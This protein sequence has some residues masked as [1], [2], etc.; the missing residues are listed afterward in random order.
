MEKCKEFVRDFI[1]IDDAIKAILTIANNDNKYRIFN[2][3]SGCGT[4]IKQLIKEIEKTLSLEINVIY[5]EGRDVD[6]PINYLDI[7]RYEKYYGKLKKSVLNLNH[8]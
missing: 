3:G 2:V 7:S 1:Y 6:V 5:K 4:S 8:F